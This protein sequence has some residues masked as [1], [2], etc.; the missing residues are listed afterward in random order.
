[1]AERHARDVVALRAHES[2]VEDP[3]HV[4]GAVGVKRLARAVLPP[5]DQ[6]GVLD[7]VRGAAGGLGERAEG[8]FGLRGEEV[9]VAVEA[10]G[11]AGNDHARVALRRRGGTSGQ[12]AP[13]A[14]RRMHPISWKAALGE[15]NSRVRR[16]AALRNAS[17]CVAMEEALQ[18]S[19]PVCN[20]GAGDTVGAVP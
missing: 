16:V 3:L 20:R 4:V 7:A 14:K 10:G 18:R 19:A 11:H 2:L 13:G 9:D 17:V 5:L 1:M 8:E 12:G 15:G 6:V